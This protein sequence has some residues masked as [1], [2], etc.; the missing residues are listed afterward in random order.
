MEIRRID[1]SAAMR[2]QRQ[3]IV[4][5]GMAHISDTIF[6]SPI[7]ERQGDRSSTPDEQI[8]RHMRK[9]VHYIEY[10]VVRRL[11]FVNRGFFFQYIFPIE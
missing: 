6:F 9:R 7:F 2:W 8:K 4:I 3:P 11:S 10:S 5:Y 1:K